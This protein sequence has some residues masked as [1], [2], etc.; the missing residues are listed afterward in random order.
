MSD[1]EN[2]DS[3]QLMVWPFDE[4]NQLDDRLV[5]DYVRQ[6]SSLGINN[7][8][9]EP[10]R[11]SDMRLA[12]IDKTQQ[13]AYNNYKTFILSGK[14]GQRVTNDLDDMQ[15]IIDNAI[16]KLPKLS[17]SCQ[18]F[19]SAA[20][21]IS[22]RWRE[23]SQM[24]SKHPQ[25]LE[26]LEI[27]QL[28]DSCVRN[29][30]YEEALQLYSYVQK[31]NKRYADSV[32]IISS[33]SK[34]TDLCREMMIN[35][36]LKELSVNIQLHSCL[37]IIGYLRR[38]DKFSETQ[39]RI[40]FL[41]ARDQWLLSLI[42]EIST[43][44]PLIHITKV[45]ET[46][47]VNLFDIVTQYRAIFADTDPIV[48]QKHL[49]YGITTNAS[50]RDFND[51]AIINSW[52]QFKINNFLNV[53]AK[54]I[55][56]CVNNE[57]GHY[58]PIESIIEPA[59]YF[60]LSMSRIGADFRPQL[61]PIIIDAICKRFLRV[62]NEATKKFETSIQ[63][64]TLTSHFV[65]PTAIDDQQ[66]EDELN[67]PLSLSEFPILAN[68][69]NDILNGMNELRRTT[70]L[71]AIAFL[72]NTL[73]DSFQRLFFVVSKYFRAEESGLTQNERQI[74]YRFCNQFSTELLQ[75]LAKC[76]DRILPMNLVANRLG[77]TTIEFNKVK[78]H[79]S[80]LNNTSIAESMNRLL[81]SSNS[82]TSDMT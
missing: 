63:N 40:K 42:K 6:L 14:C 39:L 78:D 68:Y 80:H 1:T 26:V 58:Y 44:N 49:Y 69:C 60:G 19:S 64:F 27:P 57:F 81:L 11:L 22:N 38:T 3:N 66:S 62:V 9:V 31:L 15:S 28:M 17:S 65:N 12:A 33:I 16:E 34:D 54:D 18:Q 79:F 76:F 35:Q 24:L 47:R 30:C 23:V 75:H 67:P 5:A 37:K 29:N 21:V 72:T 82:V 51:S 73:N 46:N 74:L 2:T 71:A 53:L 10:Q 41:S 4:L 70:P 43:N 45:I 13:L 52:V 48:S 61:M 50:N 36:L 25:I 8:I 55:N 20:K 56:D 32:P 59:F 77:V 7:L